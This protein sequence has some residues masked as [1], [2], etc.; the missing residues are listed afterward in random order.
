MDDELR[1]RREPGRRFGALAEE[2]AADFAR[3]ADAHDRYGRFQAEGIEAMI[4]KWTLQPNTISIVDKAMTV[5]GGAGYM[6]KHPLSRL[7]RDVRAGPSMQPFA[8]YGA[9]EFIVK[10]PR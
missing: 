5:S 2:H 6:S 1:A 8:P 7:Y 3:R 10:S 4:A 9:L